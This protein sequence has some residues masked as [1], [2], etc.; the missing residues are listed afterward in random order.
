[1]FFHKFGLNNLI[2]RF[3]HVF[4]G[5]I[6]KHIYDLN[7]PKNDIWKPFGV[8]DS[9]LIEAA[10]QAGQHSAAGGTN[11]AGQHSAVGGTNQ[12]DQYSAAGGQIKQV[13]IVQ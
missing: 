4:V 10:Y 8:D 9:F 1:M 11:Q 12:A 2:Y 6:K 7:R 3:L 5:C 13:G